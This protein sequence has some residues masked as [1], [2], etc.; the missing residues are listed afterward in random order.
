MAKFYDH[1]VENYENI[2][3]G[4]LEPYDMLMCVYNG[5]MTLHYT[6]YSTTDDEGEMVGSPSMDTLESYNS[7]IL[8]NYFS[9]QGVFLC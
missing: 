7:S 1:C 8:A 2:L 6:L 4:K 5:V 9:E 3:A